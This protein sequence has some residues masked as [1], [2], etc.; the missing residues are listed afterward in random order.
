M[1]KPPDPTGWTYLSRIAD[2]VGLATA[3]I[4]IPTLIVY[5]RALKQRLFGRRMIEATP[6]GL[7]SGFTGLICPVSAPFPPSTEPARQSEAIQKL[8]TEN[9]HPTEDLWKTPIGS[10]LKAMEHHCKDLMYCWLIASEDSRPYLV[11]LLEAARKFFPSVTVLEPVIVNDVYCKIDD[12]Y[13]A[14]HKIFDTC[15]EETSAKVHPKDIITDVTGGTKI[16]SIAMAMACL[17]ADRNIQYIEQK[18][19]KTFYKIDIT[20]EKISK[21]PDR[22]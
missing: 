22:K 6:L 5:A 8:I 14:V 20:W 16:M 9:D 3:L 1:L 18:E 13:E 10:V 17:D 7:N 4:G 15:K 21:R 2:I 12:V 11:A 19:R